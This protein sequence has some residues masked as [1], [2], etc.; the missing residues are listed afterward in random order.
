[1]SGKS[2]HKIRL[3]ESKGRDPLDARYVQFLSYYGKWVIVTTFVDPDEQFAT[4]GSTAFAE[5][6]KLKEMGFG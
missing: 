6:Q 1:M 2:K 3:A 5:I 4:S